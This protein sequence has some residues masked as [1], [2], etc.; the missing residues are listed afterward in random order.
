MSK[1]TLRDN[2]K[3]A[4]YERIVEFCYIERHKRFVVRFLDGSSCILNVTD[5]PKKLQTRKPDWPNTKLSL[6]R[7][8]LIVE[9]GD[10]LR[11]I[12]SHVIHAKGKT[13]D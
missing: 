5:L 10:S 4:E 3:I 13:G 2:N 1:N 11:E 12:P 6:D 8:A 7:S 9:V